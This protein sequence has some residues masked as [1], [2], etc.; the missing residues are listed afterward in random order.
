[1]RKLVIL[2]TFI[3]FFVIGCTNKNEEIEYFKL[4]YHPSVEKNL[5]DF[6]KIVIDFSEDEIY[7][8]Y[9]TNFSEVDKQY[10]VNDV[11]TLKTYIN[12]MKKHLDNYNRDDEREQIQVVLW[13]INIETNENKY[14][15]TGFDDYPDYW[16]KLWQVLLE[17][18]E[19]ESLE[20]FGF[21]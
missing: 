6:K 8:K 15:F 14:W 11:K 4:S 1:M 20:A 9:Y 12:S 2:L 5:D 21:E 19:A 18:S 16:D 7:I 17:T 13:N 10:L 3:M